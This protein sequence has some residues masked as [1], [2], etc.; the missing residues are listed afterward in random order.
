MSLLLYHPLPL[1]YKAEQL[2]KLLPKGR[3]V[4]ALLMPK[5][6]PSMSLSLLHPRLHTGVRSLLFLLRVPMRKPL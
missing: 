1:D 4:I 2:Q 5:S 6:Q 3:A